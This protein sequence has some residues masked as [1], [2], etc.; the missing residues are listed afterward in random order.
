M[1]PGKSRV[2]KNQKSGEPDHLV[3]LSAVDVFASKKAVGRI[4][5]LVVFEP[6]VPS[7]ILCAGG[8]E[9]PNFP[10]NCERKFCKARSRW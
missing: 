6:I 4:T 9:W 5:K 8:C 7:A 10:K 1:H 2:K 3:S